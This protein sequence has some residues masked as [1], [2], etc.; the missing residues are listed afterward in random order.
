MLGGSDRFWF[1]SGPQDDRFQGQEIVVIADEMI[2]SSNRARL[3]RDFVNA[4]VKLALP[5][6]LC[7]PCRFPVGGVQATLPPMRCSLW[8]DC[9]VRMPSQNARV[10]A[11]VIGRNST[12]AAAFDALPQ[13][14]PLALS[15]TEG[16]G[17]GDASPGAAARKSSCC[18]CRIRVQEPPSAK[19]NRNR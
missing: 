3:A 1:C 18:P 12:H 8:R 7:K 4:I 17:R 16:A 5:A 9:I 15:K 19:F 6:R 13:A 10:A 2:Y 11:G 14:S